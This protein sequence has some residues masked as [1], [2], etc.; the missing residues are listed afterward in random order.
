MDTT[1]IVPTDVPP[2]A[3][4]PPAVIVPATTLPVEAPIPPT[5]A[6]K[7]DADVT[8][9]L[10]KPILS[11]GGGVNVTYFVLLAEAHGLIFP[12]QA[13]VYRLI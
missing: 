1:A 3:A 9:T 6:A 13:E 8:P 7:F 12:L 11:T 5:G 2:P 4:I 10:P